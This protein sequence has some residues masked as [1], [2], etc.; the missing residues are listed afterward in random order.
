MSKRVPRNQNRNNFQNT[1]V[2][3]EKKEEQRIE[4]NP[5]SKLINVKLKTPIFQEGQEITEINL[6][7]NRMK[8]G[9]VLSA[10]SEFQRNNPG[11]VGMKELQDEYALR[12]ASKISGINYETLLNLEY[13]DFSVVTRELQVVFLYG[14]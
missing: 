8:A 10:G 11:F 1:Q 12:L 2:V 14:K 4:N 6:D 13:D 9:C 7:L 3:Q 5:N